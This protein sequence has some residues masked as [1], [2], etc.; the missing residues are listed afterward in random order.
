MRVHMARAVIREKENFRAIQLI[1]LTFIAL[2]SWTC[3]LVT[4]AENLLKIKTPL[5]RVYFRKKAGTVFKTRLSLKERDYAKMQME[6]CRRGCCK[7]C[8]VSRKEPQIT[9]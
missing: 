2:K 8:S 1:L 6:K 9:K 7:P 3:Q 5:N 4:N